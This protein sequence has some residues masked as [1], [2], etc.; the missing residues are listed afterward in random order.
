VSLTDER[1]GSGT[2]A[3]EGAFARFLV[4]PATTAR[5]R[6]PR[7][8]RS[9]WWCGSSRA[10]SAVARLTSRCRSG[11]R[12]PRTPRR[13]RAFPAA[14]WRPVIVHDA[15]VSTAW[16]HAGRLAVLKQ[17]ERLPAVLGGAGRLPDDGYARGLLLQRRGSSS[18]TSGPHGAGSR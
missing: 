3:N 17:V 2:G 10:R 6:S 16:Y 15:G 4:S 9:R 8:G 1:P 7:R 11:S 13:L 5:G 18:S 14:A 12:S